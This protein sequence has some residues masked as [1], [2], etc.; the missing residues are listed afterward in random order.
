MGN[1]AASAVPAGFF[2]SPGD[3]VPPAPREWMARTYNVQRYT[4]AASG[5]H[6]PGYDNAGQLVSELREFFRPLR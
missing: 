1:D 5:G 2:L 6:F 4:L 3:L